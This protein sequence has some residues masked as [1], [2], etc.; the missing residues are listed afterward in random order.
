MCSS[1]VPTYTTGQKS[2][3]RFNALSILVAYGTRG[4]I[5]STLFLLMWWPHD[6][7]S[8]FD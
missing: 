6:L 3:A 2:Y 7:G 8:M 5:Q 1:I 4:F